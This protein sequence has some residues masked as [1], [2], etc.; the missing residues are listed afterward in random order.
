[1]SISRLAR[2]GFDLPRLAYAGRTALAA[3]LA[4]MIAWLLG[5][6]HPQWAGMTVWAASQ[7][8]R[9]QLLEKSFFRFAG[10]ISG[11]IVGILLV[12][13]SNIHP[14]LL[15]AGLALWVGLCAG[16]G[17]LQRGFVSYG[18]IMAGITAAMVAL[19]DTGHPERVLHLG[20]DRMATVLTGVVVALLVGLLFAPA[21]AGTMLQVR[22]REVL[23]D[24]MQA[25]VDHCR[26][27]GAEHHAA[28]RLLADM[29]MIEEILDQHGAGSLRAR[30][31][32]RQTR[33]LLGAMIPVL[34]RLRSAAP[35]QSEAC[36]EQLEQ[37]V[38]ALH[39]ADLAAAREAMERGRA[40]VPGSDLAGVLGPLAAQLGDWERAEAA[41]TGAPE[42]VVLHRDWI[43]AREAMLR[44]MA[45]IGMSGA[46]WLVTGWSAGAYILLGLSL[47]LSMFSTFDSPATMMRSVF[48]GQGLGVIGAL[49]CRWLVWPLAETEAGMIALTMPFI[50][51]GALLAGH[52]R[53]VT[54]S[55]DYN[56]VLLLM[57]Q[58]S[59]PLV[60]SFG[61]SVLIG[62]SIVAA[63][64]IAMFAYRM[65]YPAGL[66]R[67]IATLMTM[68]VHDVQDLA[69]DP[70]ALGRRSLWR[71]R[72]YHRML[73]LVRMAERSGRND[74]PVLDGCLALLDLGHAVIHSHELLARSDITRGE[75]RVLETA[76]GRLQRLATA[77]ER[78]CA[79]L[80]QAA[81]RLSVP[82]A[83]I[84]KRAADALA[85]QAA[86]FRI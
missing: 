77:P 3:C 50:L 56:M 79:I 65:I 14:G 60:G 1:M 25:L 13:A 17:N 45:T 54:R 68:M 20:A 24:L 40:A 51:L 11:T 84:F 52:R 2:Y 46:L 12:L 86:F 43:G 8:T 83:V 21:S 75:R 53:T 32:A 27:D 15:V 39:S 31:E 73:R 63:P 55:L 74:L 38:I 28:Q 67:R 76:L 18:T 5:L 30:R 23:A 37:A 57:L 80:R 22:V 62:L 85:G 48:M 41:P 34:I 64:V 16:I 72:L 82:D 10:T 49:S 26:G 6:E 61:S 7:P 4:F 78:S 59:W 70:G 42:P 71:A 35:D 81:H 44:A 36:V 29:S 47:M 19:I 66:Q 33:R 9:G 58:P 69:A